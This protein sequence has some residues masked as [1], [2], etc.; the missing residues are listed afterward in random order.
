MTLG[1]P[2]S[3]VDC[4]A[5]LTQMSLEAL[6]GQL[7]I[8]FFQG[9]RLSPALQHMIREVQVGGLILYAVSGN[10][11][12]ARQVAELVRDAQ[13]ASAIPLWISIDQEGGAVVRLTRGVTAFPT[14]MAVAA[15]GSL[16]WAREMATALGTELRHVGINLTYAPLLDVNSNPANPIIGLRAFGRDPQQV[17]DWGLATLAGYEAAGLATT[18]KHFPGH[19]DT[20]VDSHVGLPVVTASQERLEQVELYPFRAAIRQGI[21][22]LMTAHVVVP[23]WDPDWPA[24][25]SKRILTQIL[26]QELGFTG[27]IITDSLSMG[28]LAHYASLPE[29]AIRSLEAGAD[30]ILLGADVGHTPDEQLPVFEALLNAVHNGRLSRDRIVD[31][32]RRILLTKARY[33]LWPVRDPHLLVSGR[34][35]VS[36]PDH[37]AL[38]LT[39]ARHSLTLVGET[40]LLP[41]DPHQPLL[42]LWPQDLYD[43]GSPLSG[44]FPQIRCYPFQRPHLEVNALLASL[45]LDQNL[46]ILLAIHNLERYPEQRHLVE[47]LP[48]ERTPV[49]NTGS[50]YD[51]HPC[52]WPRLITYG[53]QSLCL[54]ALVSWLQAGSPPSGHIVF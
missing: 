37:E 54:H 39:I 32:V 31:S 52:P 4:E 44:V 36:T 18:G 42:C 40:T 47:H 16:D 11:E 10:T 6:V 8:V 51:L 29:L 34:S 2:P 30:V 17:A 22:T 19:G 9:S 13:G 15:A 7:L 14:P 24:T 35:T 26:R 5:L 1:A 46:P 27:L 28:A 21:P 50:P 38:A 25:L 20:S 41:L 49:V 3:P 48:P 23:T 45:P 53:H 12:S 43:L 33:G